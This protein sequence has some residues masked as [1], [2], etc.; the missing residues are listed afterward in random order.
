MELIKQSEQKW[1]SCSKNVRQKKKKI[2]TVY[3]PLSKGSP[4]VIVYWMSISE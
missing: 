3:I 4:S 1:T 2:K